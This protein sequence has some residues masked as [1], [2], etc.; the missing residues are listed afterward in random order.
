MR[1]VYLI[2][3]VALLLIGAA[4][5]KAELDKTKVAALLASYVLDIATGQELDLSRIDDFA[6]EWA[7]DF[8]N[9]NAD[10]IPARYREETVAFARAVI[11]K[12]IADYGIATRVGTVTILGPQAEG[13]DFEEH[14]SQYLL[15]EFEKF[16]KE[17]K[18]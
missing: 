8:V 1:R 5:C 4:S 16:H 17:Y 9:D 6:A 7:V 18:K 12:L 11:P 13:D 2:V 3:L 10:E 15:D 14:L